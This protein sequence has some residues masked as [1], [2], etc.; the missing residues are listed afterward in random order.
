MLSFVQFA[1]G[2]GAVLNQRYAVGPAQLRRILDP[3]NPVFHPFVGSWGLADLA[4]AAVALGE[5][6][7]ARAYL[8]QPE[9]L[10]AQKW[11]Q[12]LRLLLGRKPPPPR[13]RPSVGRSRVW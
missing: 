6:A 3:A 8:G 1:R 7:L 11:L 4:E 9:S 5:P 10:A 2:H 12:T 13:C